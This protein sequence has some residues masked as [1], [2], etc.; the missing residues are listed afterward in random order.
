MPLDR[1][2][3]ALASGE[4]SLEFLDNPVYSRLAAQSSET[5][6]ELSARTGIP[7]EVLS[8]IREALGSP[9][10][11]QSD[12]VRDQELEIIPFVQMVVAEG[13]SAGAIER[14]LRVQGESMRR[15]AETEAEW[16]FTKVLQ[17]RIAKGLR[18]AGAVFTEI[19]PVELKGVSGTVR[20]HSARM[21]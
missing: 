13:S 3:A 14:M 11:E 12:R 21:A 20:L 2:A 15:I 16:Y 7:F 9:L 6:S 17:P 10:P 19:G 5:F 18:G 4:V 1:F 8:A